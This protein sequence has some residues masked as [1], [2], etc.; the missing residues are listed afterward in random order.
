MIQNFPFADAYNFWLIL[1]MFFLS[2]SVLLSVPHFLIKSKGGRPE[3]Y[4]FDWSQLV[5]W[6]TAIHPVLCPTHLSHY[7]L[8]R[9]CKLRL[10]FLVEFFC[11]LLTSAK[12]PRNSARLHKKLSRGDL[13]LVELLSL[14]HPRTGKNYWKKSL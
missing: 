10:L 8:W 2:I 7:L 1:P 9:C 12:M 5:Y 4:I 11:P 6:R 14:P 3:S 13:L